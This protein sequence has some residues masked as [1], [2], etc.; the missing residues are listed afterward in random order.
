[1]ACINDAGSP[2]GSGGRL[3]GITG[4]SVVS[5]GGDGCGVVGRGVGGT[6]G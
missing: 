6:C 5:G 3:T 4:L 1:M 2:S